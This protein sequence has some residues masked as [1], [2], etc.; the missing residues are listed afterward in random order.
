MARRIEKLA[1]FF[2][3]PQITK[4]ILRRMRSVP[5]RKPKAHAEA[6]RVNAYRALNLKLNL[7]SYRLSWY[8]LALLLH[9]CP[10]SLV[11]RLQTD[12]SRTPG[13]P[14]S[15]GTNWYDDVPVT[16]RKSSF[17]WSA[18]CEVVTNVSEGLSI[19]VFWWPET[20]MHS[21]T[22]YTRRD[23]YLI[24]T[25]PS[26]FPVFLSFSW[27]RKTEADIGFSHTHARLTS[28]SVCSNR[29]V[30]R[31]IKISALFQKL[32]YMSSPWPQ[33]TIHS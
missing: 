5:L 13:V 26:F 28:N 31:T 23:Y 4:W 14:S 30:C 15:K 12:K 32:L 3:W 6:R 1:F 10:Q 2:L 25:L 16:L 29:F 33:R 22:F 27:H 17:L 7:P 21:H 9:L 24:I 19:T 11:V 18:L 8:S 20:L